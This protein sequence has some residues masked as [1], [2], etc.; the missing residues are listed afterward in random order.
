MLELLVMMGITYVMCGFIVGITPYVMRKN[1]HFGIMLPDLA[2]DDQELNQWKKQ[3]LL[4]SLTLGVIC[5]IPLLISATFF[6]LDEEIIEIVAIVMIFVLFIVLGVMYIYF[7]RKVKT[8]KEAKFSSNDIS[9]D[10]RIMVATDFHN[11]KI[12]VSNGWFIVLGGIIILVTVL[13]PI[14]LFDQIPD[15]VPRHFTNFDSERNQ[16]LWLP[17][18]PRLFAIIP[19][20]QFAMLL[21]LMFVNY[22]LKIK[23]QLIVPKHAKR[24]IEQNRAYRYAMSKVMLVYTISLI[25]ILAIP[26]FLMVRGIEDSPRNMWI[27]IVWVVLLFTLFIYTML[28]YGQGGERYKPTVTAENDYQLVDD[29][30]FWKWGVFYYNPNDSAIFVE[31]RFGIGATVNFAKWQAWACLIGIFAFIGAIIIITMFLER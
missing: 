10:A 8:L 13:V 2:S 11:Q 20:I 1:V 29:D 27:V 5:F 3:F 28:K 31:K 15:Y 4:G 24:S 16:L 17:K 9:Q 18:T 21:L 23:K 12:V 25:L 14:L 6:N 22:M 19:L 30:K 26:Q 7:H